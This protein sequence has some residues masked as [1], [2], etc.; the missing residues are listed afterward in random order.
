[1]ST[2]LRVKPET[3]PVHILTNYLFKPHFNTVLYLSLCLLSFLFPS[4][5]QTEISCAYRWI[6]RE[7]GYQHERKMTVAHY[8]V[9]SRTLHYITL[10]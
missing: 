1:V 6:L 8:R 3:D 4:D 7:T 2:T 9:E 10:H 5:L